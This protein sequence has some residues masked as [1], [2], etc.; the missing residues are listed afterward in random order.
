MS[1][2]LVEI[3]IKIRECLMQMS[4]DLHKLL[5]TYKDFLKDIE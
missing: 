2:E 5:E 3:T 1:K 4:D